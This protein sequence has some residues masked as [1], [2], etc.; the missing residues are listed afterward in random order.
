[1][2]EVEYLPQGS[3][4]M[5]NK[6]ILLLALL[7]LLLPS[8]IVSQDK[9]ISPSKIISGTY[10]GETPPLRDLPGLTEAEW[11][12]MA[13]KAEQ[14][15]LNPK[16]RTRSFP[17]AE[18]ALPKGP[19]QAWQ[20]EMGANRDSWPPIMNFN[21]QAS[22]YYPPD[23][24]GTIGPNHY[25]QTINSNYAIYSRSG[26]LLAGPTN[27]N[28]LFSGV[29]GSNCNDGDPII[30]YDEQADRWLAAEFSLCGSNDYMLIAVSTTNDPTGTWHKYSFD[31]ADVPDYEKFGIWRNGYYMGTNT[32]PGN[33]IYVFERSQML[34]GGPAQG[35]GFDNPWRPTTL[36]G[37]MCVPPLDNDGAF[38]PEG[39]PGLFITINDDAIGGGSD[40]LWIYELD[41]DWITPSS[42]TFT[43]TQQINVTAFDSNFGNN[44]D[45]IKQP[46][47]TRELDAIPQVIM[48]PPQ[49]RNFGS[50][51]TILCCHTVDVDAT[52]HAGIRWYELR[53]L[54]GGDWTIRQQGTYAP[55]AHSRW[56]GSMVLNG[57]NEIALAYSVSS[58]SLYPGI[59]YCGQSSSAYAAATGI[60]DIS[61]A[62][63]HTGAYSQTASFRWGDYSALQVDPADDHTF[64]Y[65]NQ[66]VG[67]SDARL[68]KIASFIFGPVVLNAIFSSTNVTPLPNTAVTFTDLS[69]GNPTSWTWSFSPNT[70]TYLDGTSSSSQNPQV[71]FNT[72]GF[73]T[74]SLTASANNSNDTETRTD[75]IHAHYPDLWTGATSAD[76]SDPSNWDGTILPHAASNV[77]L[78]A[79]AIHWPEFNGDFSIGI[80]CN[81]LTFSSESMMTINGN[82][83]IRLKKNLDMTAGGFIELSGNWLNNGNFT[84]GSGI[85]KFTGDGAVDVYNTIITPDIDKYLITSFPKG[86]TELSGASIGPT[87]NDGSQ[88]V[89][90]GFDFN[91]A[92]TYYSM[93][94][95]STNGWLSLNLT[96]GTGYFN[97][98]LFSV[99]VP[100]ATIAPWWDDL[101]DDETSF[102]YYKTEGDAPNRVFTAEWNRV[103]TWRTI[104]TARISFQ[105]KLYET[106]NIIEFHYGTFEPGS[107]SVN[108][109][110]S[111]G[112]EDE[113]GGPGHFL[114]ATTGSTTMGVTNLVSPANWPAVNYRFTPAP[115]KETFTNVVINNTGGP[116]NFTLDTDIIE[117]L[118]VM[119]GGSF[120]VNTGKTLTLQGNVVE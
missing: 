92:G 13:E 21:G 104:A 29:T 7:P 87:G 72:S 2:E 120:K 93:L 107:H 114:E 24:N 15:M 42:S 26:A 27:M 37:F 109:S 80:H 62:I 105:V 78:P 61:E 95:F 100:N 39:E 50:Y 10:H 91:Y 51:E 47:T 119:S 41:V 103:L 3:I 58:A 108:E 20:K 71:S 12:Q 101:R 99:S 98:D 31:V 66:Y 86:M 81:S 97:A 59:R 6:I 17:Y 38:A 43:R 5:K 63:I 74:V 64:W 53:R 110:A 8:Q 35:V 76:W 11:Q 40:Q 52:D 22:S 56:M 9:A 55:D 118:T 115:Y 79:A 30:L 70:V 68:T 89:T 28:L 75:F 54:A 48:N 57:Q 60:L 82:F 112:L 32:S 16:L 106:T 73:Y 14:K 113:Y 83:T 25:M 4:I 18:T 84:P 65:I 69:T 23:A 67:S 85:V 96:G 111:I 34:I 44:W 88:D 46:G 36:D 33:D 116:V 102:L 90:I 77:T 19:D 45:N 49:Y 117:N 1:L 94:K